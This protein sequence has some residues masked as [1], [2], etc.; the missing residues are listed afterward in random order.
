MYAITTKYPED[1]RC[2][3]YDSE[4]DKMP[5]MAKLYIVRDKVVPKSCDEQ[6][7]SNQVDVSDN[8][9]D[10]SRGESRNSYLDS[11]IL[12]KNKCLFKFNR[13]LIQI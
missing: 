4:T 7:L 8:D 13:I 12:N 5:P 11:R 2:P 6:F 9:E 3:F 10:A 1:P